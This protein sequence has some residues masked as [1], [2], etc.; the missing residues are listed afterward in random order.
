MRN[1]RTRLAR[2]E[3]K[4]SHAKGNEQAV[5]FDWRNEPYFIALPLDKQAN[6]DAT[7]DKLRPFLPV[8]LAKGLESL[9]DEELDDL[10]RL[11]AAHFERVDPEFLHEAR[12]TVSGK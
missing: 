12:K 6:L 4:V 8:N 7:I 5:S 3:D 11:Y 1:V 9:S 10:E 2:L